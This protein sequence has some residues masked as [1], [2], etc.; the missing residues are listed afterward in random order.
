MGRIFG[1]AQ[2]LILLLVLAV[3]FGVSN[4]AKSKSKSKLNTTT[5]EVKLVESKVVRML[6]NHSSICHRNIVSQ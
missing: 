1:S 4:C 3:Y 5:S 2:I 6:N